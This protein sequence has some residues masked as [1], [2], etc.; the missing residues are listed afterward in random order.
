MEMEAE[1]MM[2]CNV[3]LNKFK[4]YELQ[5]PRFCCSVRLC[6]EC[7]WETDIC[8]QC[9]SIGTVDGIIAS[10]DLCAETLGKENEL[11]K[12]ENELQEKEN[13]MQK[14]TIRL[15]KRENEL[16]EEKIR[17][18]KEHKELQKNRMKIMSEMLDSDASEDE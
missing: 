16:Q 9:R 6:S 12:R 8:P 5:N 4:Y 3:C 14:D 15:L 2:E 7:Y 17:L 13:E 18:L 10:L 1:S 11:L